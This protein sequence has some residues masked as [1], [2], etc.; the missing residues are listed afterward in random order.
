MSNTD[1]DLEDTETKTAELPKAPAP[2]PVELELD[3][4]GTETA[5][6]EDAAELG[7]ETPLETEPAKPSRADARIQKIL[8]RAKAAEEN[9]AKEREERIREQARREMLER[10]QES[11]KPQVDPRE[12]EARLAEMSPEE[13]SAYNLRK[14]ERDL[15][16]KIELMKFEN[17]D[18]ADKM[19]YQT[20]AASDPRYAKYAG[21][22]EEELTRLRKTGQNVPREI[23]LQVVIGRAV[24]KNQ[25]KAKAQAADAKRNLELQKAAPVAA[26]GD[27]TGGA[28]VDERS[29]RLK[30]LANVTL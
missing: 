21:E 29:A 3:D 22:V 15:S 4:Q 1:F 7:A 27:Q 26:K 20:K 11:Q 13:R 6:T 14:T 30:R 8:E 10:F 16:F 24:L 25:P 2:E 18:S 19:A 23:L 5:T 9:L 28:K 17:A 12:E